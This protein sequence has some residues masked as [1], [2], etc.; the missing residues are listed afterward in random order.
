MPENIKQL[1][2]MAIFFIVIGIVMFYSYSYPEIGIY[3]MAVLAI[4]VVIYALIR[5]RTYRG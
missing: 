2:S 5:E 1:I 3:I 4:L